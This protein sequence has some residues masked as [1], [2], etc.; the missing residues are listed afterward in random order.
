MLNFNKYNLNNPI[1]ISIPLSANAK[2]VSAWYV[3]PPEF[4]AVENGTWVGDVNRGGSVNFRN[5]YFNPHGH[6]THTECVGHISKEFF[7]INKC[8]KT[9]FFKS[10]LVSIMPLKVD[11]DLVIMLEQLKSFNNLSEY[12]AL[13]IR[14]LPNTEEKLTKQY[15]HTNF[16]YIHADALKL[17]HDMG[18]LH[19]LVDLPSV[20]KENDG[21]KLAGHRAFWNYPDKPRLNA[22][23]TEFIYVKPSIIDG[24][25]LLN[26]Q[27]APFENDA[28]PSKPVLYAL[29]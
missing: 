5:I 13:I 14:T 8:L 7:T 17:I 22:T 9:F 11:E 16:P 6:G 4:K 25:Y 15:S 18:I 19:L 10:L 12:D 26:L 23:I 3:G 29:K 21:G 24:E 2:N 20:D 28:S 27:I 1:D